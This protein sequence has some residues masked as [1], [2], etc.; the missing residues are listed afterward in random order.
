MRLS[1]IY[2]GTVSFAQPFGPDRHIVMKRWP[3]GI[4]GLP[5]QVGRAAETAFGK[6]LE[7]ILILICFHWNIVEEDF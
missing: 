4:L 6:K 7:L 2:A 1:Y 5:G 3:T